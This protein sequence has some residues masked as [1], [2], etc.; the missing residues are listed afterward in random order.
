MDR[1]KKRLLLFLGG[2]AALIGAALAYD[3]AP[4]SRERAPRSDAELFAE[5]VVD[6]VPPSGT[7]AGAEAVAVQLPRYRPPPPTPEGEMFDV[8]GAV[9]RHRRQ[10]EEADGTNYFNCDGDCSEF[11]HRVEPPPPERPRDPIPWPGA[12][13]AGTPADE[14][15]IGEPPQTP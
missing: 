12:P 6:I 11:E 2:G 14:A 5:P 9:T 7:S 8:A 4:G 10:A 3:S 13:T 1:D 15:A